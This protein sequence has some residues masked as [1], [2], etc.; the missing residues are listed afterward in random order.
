MHYVAKSGISVICH[1]CFLKVISSL[2]VSLHSFILWKHD[3]E[4]WWAVGSWVIIW[5][6]LNYDCAV[7]ASICP[8]NNALLRSWGHWFYHYVILS[9]QIICTCM[10]VFCGGRFKLRFAL[11]FLLLSCIP[12]HRC[13]FLGFLFWVRSI[14]SGKTAAWEPSAH[15]HKAAIVQ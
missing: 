2:C 12:M 5:R 13:F 1:Y 8:Y 15:C 11:Q 3:Y 6:H 4:M 9:L 7:L 10:D 14:S